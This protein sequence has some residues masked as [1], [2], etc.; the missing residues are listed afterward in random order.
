MFE[1]VVLG[2]RV[3]NP[4][5]CFYGSHGVISSCLRALFWC[6]KLEYLYLRALFWSIDNHRSASKPFARDNAIVN[7]LPH[8]T[9]INLMKQ[10]YLLVR[11]A[12]EAT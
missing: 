1:G 6:L 3:R 8:L 10:Y 7:V 5:F 12:R 9:Y 4:C 11:H 2:Q